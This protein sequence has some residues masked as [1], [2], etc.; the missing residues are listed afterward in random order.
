M[1]LFIR[2]TLP[3]FSQNDTSKMAGDNGITGV[4]GRLGQ[5]ALGAVLQGCVP[6]EVLCPY[7]GAG[8]QSSMLYLYYC[9]LPGNRFVNL[10]LKSGI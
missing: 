7:Y 5:A 10:V 3:H 9:Y 1:P 6:S 8:K 2:G 4:E